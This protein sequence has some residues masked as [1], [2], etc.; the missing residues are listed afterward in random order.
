MRLF[1]STVNATLSTL[2]VSAG[3]DVSNGF[4]WCYLFVVS[5]EFIAYIVCCLHEL[6]RWQMSFLHSRPEPEFSFIKFM[7]TLPPKT[8]NFEL[9]FCLF[10]ANFTAGKRYKRLVAVQEHMIMAFSRDRRHQRGSSC[11]LCGYSVVKIYA[12]S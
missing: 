7:N 12:P 6:I 5:C 11:S 9:F 1:I 4:S 2:F 3:N 8:P 10:S